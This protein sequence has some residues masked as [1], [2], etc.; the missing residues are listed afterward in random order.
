MAAPK[1]SEKSKVLISQ[2]IPSMVRVAGLWE[3]GWN[4]PIKEVDLWEFPLRDFEVDKFYMSPVSGI[5]HSMVEERHSFEDLL[6]EARAEGTTLVF[7]DEM[8]T[9][10]L[11]DFSHPENVLYVFGKSGLNPLKAYGQKEDLS[12]VIETKINGGILWPHQA[13]AIVLY[14]RMMKLYK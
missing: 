4:T 14:D 7:V 12:V 2:V 6:K 11:K 1:H 3:L 13:A 5:D 9:T 10:P 8:A